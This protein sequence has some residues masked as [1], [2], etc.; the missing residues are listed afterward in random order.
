[1]FNLPTE[2]VQ[3]IFEF[4]IDKRLSWNKLNQQFLKGGFNRK[5]LKLN[6]YL[7]REQWCCKK[8][9]GATRP[10]VSGLMKLWSPVTRRMEPCSFKTWIKWN[11]KDKHAVVTFRIS[12][13][14][15][16]KWSG[17]DPV[18]KWLKNISKFETS[19]P[20]YAKETY[21]PK[22]KSPIKVKYLSKFYVDRRSYNKKKIKKENE[23]KAASLFME[24]RKQLK[25]DKCSFNKNQEVLLSFTMPSGKL[26][27][28]RGWVYLIYLH[29][30]RGG[31]GYRKIFSAPRGKNRF[32]ALKI[33]NYIGELRIMI[34]FEDGDYKQYT[35]HKLIE[36][37]QTSAKEL[38]A[39]EKKVFARN[40]KV[41]EEDVVALDTIDI[42]GVTYLHDPDGVYAGI[43]HL[44]L[45]E[46]GTPLGIY[47]KNNNRLIEHE[48][49][50]EREFVE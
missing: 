44:L 8:L 3:H 34:R 47:D 30:H 27:F 1:M 33:D 48:F 6:R 11:I 4:C 42:N 37:I 23:K 25:L 31:N 14:S 21:L 20:E 13:R 29:Q 26:K 32:D 41:S 7:E 2:L 40:N 9:W 36:R 28:Y 39:K 5:N 15:I 24:E 17:K 10:E 16:V 19:H 45:S 18:S 12:G 35:N 50:I 38:I 46:D 49:V 22:T 43:K